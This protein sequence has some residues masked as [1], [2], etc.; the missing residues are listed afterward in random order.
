MTRERSV[1]V[2]ALR[3]EGNARE[4]RDLEELLAHVRAQARKKH[5]A[6]VE[7]TFR[8]AGEG[9]ELVLRVEVQE[10]GARMRVPGRGIYA[11]SLDGLH[12]ALGDVIREEHGAAPAYLDLYQALLTER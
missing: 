5:V 1:E 12:R 6:Q 9:V 2:T 7:A 3:F 8:F 11:F 10:R 4:A